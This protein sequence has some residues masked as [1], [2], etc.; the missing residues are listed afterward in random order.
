MPIL[1]GSGLENSYRWIFI[2]PCSFMILNFSAFTS[3][4]ILIFCSGYF[5]ALGSLI[6]DQPYRVAAFPS[7]IKP[8]KTIGCSANLIE[9]GVIIFLIVR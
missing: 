3:F 7:A 1:I 4:L 2:R 9:T 6:A 5:Y 8:F